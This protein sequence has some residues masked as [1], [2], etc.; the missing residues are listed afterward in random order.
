MLTLSYRTFLL[1]S[2]IFSNF[3]KG[4]FPGFVKI[5]SF[6]SLKTEFHNQN[7]VLQKRH[8]NESNHLNVFS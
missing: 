5:F 6:F 2:L 1:L 4:H 3:V 7:I 8:L